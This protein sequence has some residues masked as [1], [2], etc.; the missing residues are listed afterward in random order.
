MITRRR[1]TALLAGAPFASAAFAHAA[2]GAISE[3][4][5]AAVERF[6]RGLVD[7]GTVPG[8]SF[9]IGN[10]ST[11]LMEGG[12][13]LRALSPAEPMQA[14]TRCA[15][16]SV[17]KQFAAAAIFLLQQRGLVS[18]DAPLSH[19][20]PEYVYARDM[21]LAQL[22]TMRAGV[23]ADDEICEAPIEGKIDDTTLIAN[24]NRHKLDFAPGSYFSYTNCGYNVAGVVVERISK[25]SYA[26]FLRDNFFGPLGM[27]SSY[28][29]AAHNDVNLAQGYARENGRWQA[30]PATRADKAFASGNLV[31]T[32]ADIQRWD[33]S[34]FNATILSRTSLHKMFEVPTRSGPAHMH[35]ANGWFVEPS[36][37]IWH[38]GTLAGYGTMN[39]LV[40]STG[41]AIVLLSNTGPSDKWKPAD[42]AR[43]VY[44][45]A[46]LGP[47][48]P[49]L[50]PRTRSTAPEPTK[51]P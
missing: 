18:L 47:P 28:V 14:A 2:S 25:K 22:L 48:L 45:T 35:Y 23:A 36:G 21:T 4:Q 8:I 51:S 26:Q 6:L 41:Y 3:R 12:V 49:P 17:S 9:S 29:L 34:L 1:F 7:S 5:R 32:A 16:A 37:A 50:L 38:G 19:Y 42:A 27:H 40:P 13:G 33:R 30:A 46:E 39:L 31:S 10:A 43:E 20:L 44:N 11:M 15:L 24:L